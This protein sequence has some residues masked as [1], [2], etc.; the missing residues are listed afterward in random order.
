MA[1]PSVRRLHYFNDVLEECVLINCKADN[2]LYEQ[3]DYDALQ[4]EV[5]AAREALAPFARR[6]EY[7]DKVLLANG[8]KFPFPDDHGYA[9]DP[10]SDIYIGDLRRA[11]QALAAH[12]KKDK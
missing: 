2:H 8:G 10:P 6:A 4:R 1:Q 12:G 9:D 11:Q 3:A 5:E 7:F